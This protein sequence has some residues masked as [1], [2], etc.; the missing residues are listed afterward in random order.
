M[1]RG[2]SSTTA[3]SQ[4]ELSTTKGNGESLTFVTESPILDSTGV[5]P[6]YVLG[7]LKNMLKITIKN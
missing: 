7:V 3:T 2:A 1:S 6:R 4:M 5:L